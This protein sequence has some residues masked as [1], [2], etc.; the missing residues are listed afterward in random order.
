MHSKTV[1]TG[2]RVC[3]SFAVLCLSLVSDAHAWI[4]VSH[5]PGS[6]LALRGARMT[7]NGYLMRD[8][9]K[10]PFL[11]APVHRRR[12][13]L[14]MSSGNGDALAEAEAALD[15][16]ISNGEVESI[17]KCLKKIEELQGSAA[18][19]RPFDKKMVS[20]AEQS[21]EIQ[22]FLGSQNDEAVDAVA[23]ALTSTA[24]EDM[25][26]ELQVAEAAIEW[27]ISG[28]D[29]PAVSKAMSHLQELQELYGGFSSATP[30]AANSAA[31][32]WPDDVSRE[33]SEAL[34][35]AALDEGLD[36]DDAE[37]P[38]VLDSLADLLGDVEDESFAKTVAEL[39]LDEAVANCDTEV[40]KTK[41]C[42]SA[43]LVCARMAGVVEVCACASECACACL[44]R[45][46]WTVP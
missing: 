16:A 34:E 3:L 37:I 13:L 21:A 8:A 39:E 28:N 30:F 35:L 6:I 43:R 5:V 33:I 31:L 18:G 29:T 40:R 42:A 14:R 10:P 1:L 46:R 17:S 4:G 22:E 15:D 38:K 36:K 9:F 27:A 32:P 20:T 19:M 25:A 45:R 23:D 26:T 44:W 2:P 24:L 41:C 12:P 7:G 11:L